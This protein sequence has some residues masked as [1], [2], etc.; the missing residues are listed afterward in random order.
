MGRIVQPKGTKG[1][2][3]WIQHVINEYP[4]LLNSHIQSYLDDKEDL[5]IEWLSPRADVEYAEY[6]DQAFLDLLGIRLQKKKLKDFWPNRGPQWDALGIIED[7]AY[8]FV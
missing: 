4:E 6:R 5:A 8:F 7:K 1:S 3:K 2:L